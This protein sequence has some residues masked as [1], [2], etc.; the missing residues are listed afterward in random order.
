M[1]LFRPNLQHDALRKL[2]A[3]HAAS[4]RKA[5]TKRPALASKTAP[6]R[7]EKTAAAK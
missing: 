2:A 1:T 7:E 4:I 6:K 3:L 5:A